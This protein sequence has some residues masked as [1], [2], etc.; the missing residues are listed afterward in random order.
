GYERNMPPE[1]NKQLYQLLT[2]DPGLDMK[3]V[4]PLVRQA[5]REIRNV[6]DDLRYFAEDAGLNVGATDEPWLHRQ[7]QM[8]LL[9][10]NPG[11]EA[12][13]L[14]GARRTYAD[15]FDE[16][17]AAANAA[18]PGLQ[19]EIDA[20]QAEAERLRAHATSLRGVRGAG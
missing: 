14:E 3:T 8:H 6:L 12:R 16:R 15:Q 7:I 13:F 9:E 4:S 19:A 11:S 17:V 10:A 18:R 5:A 1:I 2:G 20:A